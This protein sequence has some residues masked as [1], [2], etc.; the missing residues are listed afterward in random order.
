MQLIILLLFYKIFTC[1]ILEIIKNKR[2]IG[3]LL[4][5]L[6]LKA[7]YNRYFKRYH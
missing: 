5:I 1:I 6:L 2:T 3:I 7:N 4:T